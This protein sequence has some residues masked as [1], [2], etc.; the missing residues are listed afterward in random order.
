MSLK[1]VRVI[2]G[3]A[4]HPAHFAAVIRYSLAPDHA[5]HGWASVPEVE[6]DVTTVTVGYYPDCPR[7]EADIS[8]GT[9]DTECP[10]GENAICHTDPR[11]TGR[12]ALDLITKLTG[13][14]FRGEV[15]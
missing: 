2:E 13:I 4:A 11:L 5:A 7:L 3:D 1:G 14:T 15:I 10:C 12:Q 6:I 9:L 8:F